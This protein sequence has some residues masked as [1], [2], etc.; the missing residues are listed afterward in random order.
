M[1][2]NSPAVELFDGAMA[3]VATVAN[4]RHAS[5][6]DMRCSRES[7]IVAGAVLRRRDDAT[8]D[9]AETWAARRVVLIDDPWTWTRRSKRGGVA[10]AGNPGK[11][12]EM[13]NY[14]YSTTTAILNNAH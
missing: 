8:T 14:S 9:A 1:P 2:G 4:Q 11:T 12:A 7:G 10:S 5:G 6:H 3:A 13:A